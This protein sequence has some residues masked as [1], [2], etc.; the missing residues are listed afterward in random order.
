MDITSKSI[1]LGTSLFFLVN[2]LFALNNKKYK[3]AVNYTS[4][5]HAIGSTL[6]S[7]I[8]VSSNKFN[9]LNSSTL[10]L[11]GFNI[12]SFSSGYF[13]H[14]SVVTCYTLNGL[15][16]IIFLYHHLGA[17]LMIN[18]NINFP[19]Y[20]ILFWAELSNLPYYVVY[21]H[22]HQP[23]PNKEKII[24]WKNI[25]KYLYSIIRIPI[26]GYYMYNQF[27]YN[28]NNNM[29]YNCMLAPVYFLGCGWTLKMFIEN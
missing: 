7:L 18:S 12:K 6:M 27:Y 29:L 1:V 21:Y 25:Q 24:L 19:V 28:N 10:A 8:Y 15:S 16:R 20:D 13:I 22:L 2:G 26:F 11:L 9:L 14:D 4:A 23:H 3:M 5:V 17:L